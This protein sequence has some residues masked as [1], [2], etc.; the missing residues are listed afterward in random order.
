MFEIKLLPTPT[1][2]EN[3]VLTD[4]Q[5]WFLLVVQIPYDSFE[6]RKS[7]CFFLCED[8]HQS[9]DIYAYRSQLFRLFHMRNIPVEN[10]QSFS[11]PTASWISART[12]PT[13]KATACLH[14]SSASWDIWIKKSVE[15]AASFTKIHHPE[16]GGTVFIRHIQSVLSSFQI[17]SQ[18]SRRSI[19][20]STKHPLKFPLMWLPD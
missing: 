14:S 10:R 18:N 17:V 1:Q 4:S 13:I 7:T 11:N 12:S 20:I 3:L 16:M 5:P 6:L 9:L 15:F 19:F 2:Q 8:P